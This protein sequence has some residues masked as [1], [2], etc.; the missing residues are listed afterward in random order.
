MNI[1]QLVKEGL[2]LASD[3]GADVIIVLEDESGDLVAFVGNEGDYEE[4]DRADIEDEECALD[5]LC[6]Y[7]EGFLDELINVEDKGVIEGEAEEV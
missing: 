4:M 2:I 3:E 7:A 6:E 5:E 1:H